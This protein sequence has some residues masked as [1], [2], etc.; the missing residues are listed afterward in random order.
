MKL[1][2]E[3]DAAHQRQTYLGA[4]VPGLDPHRLDRRRP[5]GTG[6]L[7]PK[8]TGMGGTS[9]QGRRPREW[10]RLWARPSPRTFRRKCT[11]QTGLVNM[12]TTMGCTASPHR[13]NSTRWGAMCGGS[14]W[15][16]CGR[17]AP[18]SR[19][20]PPLPRRSAEVRQANGDLDA[21]ARLDGLAQSIGGDEV[22]QFISRASYPSSLRVRS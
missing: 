7:P 11:C 13:G 21:L 19:S 2:H 8:L 18:G 9:A 3:P 14:P 22:G 1:R 6:H 17:S 12:M 20:A 4:R 16:P 10:T 15:R 5:R